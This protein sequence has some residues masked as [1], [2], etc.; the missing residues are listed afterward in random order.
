MTNNPY[1]EFIP[2][3]EPEFQGTRLQEGVIPSLNF[4]TFTTP[5]YVDIQ[6]KSGQKIIYLGDSPFKE[7]YETITNENEK[8]FF[9]E[10]F[11]GF[12][13]R[14]QISTD[15]QDEYNDYIQGLVDEVGFEPT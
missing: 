13:I 11:L 12:D 15:K 1:G 2:T 3:D 14:N 4:P 5:V 6:D 9:L 7:D 10:S 8:S